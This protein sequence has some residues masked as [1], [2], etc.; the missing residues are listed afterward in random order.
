MKRKRRSEQP[1]WQLMRDFLL[2]ITNE[3]GIVVKVARPYAEK[4]KIPYASRLSYIIKKGDKIFNG[5]SEPHINEKSK[6]FLKKYN[7]TDLNKKRAKKD[8]KEPQVIQQKTVQQELPFHQETVKQELTFQSDV[9]LD[10][11]MI[12]EA[13]RQVLIEEGISKKIQ[14]VNRFIREWNGD[15]NTVN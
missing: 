4:L 9:K 10:L 3:N 6:E 14:L 12:K 2:A 7:E 8:K 11:K 15:N 1:T 13:V 5:Q